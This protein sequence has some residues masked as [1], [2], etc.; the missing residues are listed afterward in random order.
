[1]LWFSGVGALAERP[2]RRS[3]GITCCV[4]LLL[5]CSGVPT[6]LASSFLTGDEVKPRKGWEDREDRESVKRLQAER[7][8]L[9]LQ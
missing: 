2:C 4:L 3:P 7:L 6:S 5:N 8:L 9:S 1:M